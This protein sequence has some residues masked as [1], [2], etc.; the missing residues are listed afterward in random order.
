MNIRLRQSAKLPGKVD[1]QARACIV[2]ALADEP[3]RWPRT[4]PWRA[5][6]QH[7]Y[8]QMNK[9]E[10]GIM[11]LPQARGIP[12]SYAVLAADDSPFTR[13]ERARR[14]VAAHHA[15]R[16]GDMALVL[17][18]YSPAEGT[19]IAEALISAALASAAPLPNF[20]QAHRPSRLTRLYLYGHRE[21]DGFQRSFCEAEGNALARGLAMLPGNRL[22][23]ADYL[24]QLRELAATHDWQLKFMDEAA[25]ARQ[26]AGAFLS[27]SA[28]STHRDAG[29]V[30]L[31]YRPAHRRRRRVALVGKGICYDTGGINLKPARYMYGMH[32]DMQGSAVALGTLLALTRLQVDFPVDCWLALA[33]NDIGP[34]A[35]VPGDVVTATDGTTIELIHTD[36]EGRMVLADTLALARRTRGLALLLDYATLTGACVQALGNGYSGVFSNR[37]QWL[38]AL[39]EAG[40][41]CGERIWP[42]PMD[43]DYDR[44]LQSD[45]ADIKQCSLR[46]D[47]DHILAARFLS[48]FV[49]DVPWLH[50]D[51]SASACKGG[52]AHI[53]TE[54]TGFGVRLSLHVLLDGV[55]DD[56]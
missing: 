23:P 30:R 24:S 47:A 40:R 52:L 34:N 16:P 42:F 7:H 41:N 39:L 48:R 3:A 14:L 28:G 29:I 26:G 53:P 25:L 2:L 46:G 13:L 56:I 44:N 20:R 17:A 32:G 4:L 49:G 5:S 31:Q 51:L 35:S 22:G 15:C 50:L 19:V 11:T 43:A 8:R 6:I 37:P 27:V 18:G 45:I 1:L 21:P 12:L 33:R 38:P 36:A 54:L 9:P 55:L 10:V